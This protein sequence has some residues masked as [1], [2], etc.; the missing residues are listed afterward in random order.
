MLI[1]LLYFCCTIVD[2]IGIS[3]AQG[4]F[5]IGNHLH[6]SR[7]VCLDGNGL[8][9][10]ILG[11]HTLTL[12]LHVSL[13]IIDSS[14]F[15]VQLNARFSVHLAYI[16]KGDGGFLHEHG[17]RCVRRLGSDRRLKRHACSG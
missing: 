3:V 12:G 2:G 15:V 1:L 5:H 17:L 16:D 4:L 14:Q 6:V 11:L 8:P 9:P 10:H 7:A 13:H